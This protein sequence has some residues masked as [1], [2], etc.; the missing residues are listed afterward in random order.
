MDRGNMIIT[1]GPDEHRDWPVSANG[2]RGLTRWAYR[3]WGWAV[4]VAA[5]AA[6]AVPSLTPSVARTTATRPAGVTLPRELRSFVKMPGAPPGVI[7]LVQRSRR[8]TVYRAGVSNLSSHREVEASDHMRLASVAKAF[9]GAVALSLVNR[10]VLCL[11]DTIAKWLPELPKA[12][13]A[14]TLREALQHTSGLPDFSVSDGFTTYLRKH[15]HATPSPLFLLHFIAH[16]RLAFHPG[17]RYHYSNTDNFVV[18]LMTE[19]ATKR[20]YPALLSSEVNSPLG[21]THTSLPSGFRMPLPYM[22]GYQPDP[23]NPPEDVSTTISAAYAWASGGVVSTPADLN[24]FIRGY[25]GARLFSR[26]VQA[27]QLRLVKGSSQ[28]VGPGKNMAG[29]GIFRY[30]T[31]CGTVYGHTG[32]TP[33]YTQF[34]AAT[35]DG[36]R[37]VTVSINS[38]LTEKVPRD[39]L[40][41]FRRLREIEEDA[42]CVALG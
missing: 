26:A 24:R 33:G 27:Q 40:P 12:W 16:Q 15:L 2:E 32:N 23:P 17:T 42:V 11:N 39:Q 22:H 4:A 8:P 25:A 36:K 34:T 14:V 7:V 6:L 19:A 38:Q 10:H 21:L 18:G 13:G 1:G 28:P 37:S 35:R 31:R 5:V 3:R 9:S 29:L 20:S 30:S 41:A